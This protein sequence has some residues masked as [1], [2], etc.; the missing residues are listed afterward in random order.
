MTKTGI[1]YGPKPALTVIQKLYCDVCLLKNARVTVRFS[2]HYFNNFS[3]NF[4]GVAPL[5]CTEKPIWGCEYRR[6]LSRVHESYS[7]IKGSRPQNMFQMSKRS[8]GAENL[9]FA[10]Y[11]PLAIII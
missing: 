9:N 10:R 7:I 4:Y 2:L 11:E 5:C 1:D 3:I 6:T 8:S